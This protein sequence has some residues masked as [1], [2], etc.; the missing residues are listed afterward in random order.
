A[1]GNADRCLLSH[2]PSGNNLRVTLS[3][4]SGVQIYLAEAIGG[5]FSVTANEQYEIELNVDS[6]NGVIRL[7]INGNLHG[8]LNP[9]SWAR[10]TNQARFYLGAMPTIYN[11]AD[12][13][14]D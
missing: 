2:S 13:S 12:A 1:T 5:S 9:G 14:F 3:D 8:T 6:I 4:S 10:D 11:T 7:F